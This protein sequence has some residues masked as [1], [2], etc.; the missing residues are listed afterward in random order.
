MDKLNKCQIK[1]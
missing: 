1:H